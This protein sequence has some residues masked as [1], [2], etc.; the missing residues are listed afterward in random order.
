MEPI[1]KNF[2]SVF[3]YLL[4]KDCSRIWAWNLACLPSAA[5]EIQTIPMGSD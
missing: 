5:Q 1:K 3:V 2:M 4:L